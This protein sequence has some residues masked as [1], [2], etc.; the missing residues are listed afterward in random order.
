MTI[1]FFEDLLKKPSL[2]KKESKLDNDFI[3]KRLPHREK[4][5][6]LL[7][8]LFLV[9]ITNP[10]SISR[11]L[12]II[13]KTG[14]GKTATIKL[15]GE[16]LVNAA[17]KRS[18]NI[19]HVHINCRKERTSY[20]VLIKI[21]RTLN[22]NFPKRGYSPQ[23]LLEIIVDIIKDQNLHLLIVLD[24]LSYLIGKDGDLIY[25][26]TRINDDSFNTRQH[27][28]I[29]GIARDIS[30]L[31]GLDTSTMSTL[32]RNIIY[33]KNYTKEQLFDILKYRTEISLKN[34]VIS[35]NLI[36]MIVDLVYQSG[37]IRYGLNLLWKSTKIAENQNLKYITIEAIRLANQDIVPFSTIDILKYMSTQK[38]IFLLAVI[39]SLD[40]CGGIHT[41]VHEITELYLILCES[42]G[43]KPRSHSQLWNYLQEFKK[44]YLIT[45]EIVSESIKGRKAQISIQD[46]PIS[47]YKEFILEIIETKGIKI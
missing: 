11:K 17:Q 40:K 30:C 35:D 47:K 36:H 29:L 43:M 18:A 2:F 16:M 21:V 1:D 15:F 31:S 12:L 23:D 27:I 41:S 9:L 13:G 32:Q 3:P 45:M 38:I 25:S 4:E 33:F 7:S 20:K 8:Q 26:L 10:N 28:S 14:I 6:S 19:R 44:E 46:I 24:E 22:N 37:D 34:N 5:L 39:N 42:L